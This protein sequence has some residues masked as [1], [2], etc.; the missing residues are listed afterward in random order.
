MC[1]R[2]ANISSDGIDHIFSKI[3]KDLFQLSLKQSKTPETPDQENGNVIYSHSSINGA[4]GD[5]SH[6]KWGHVIAFLV[7]AGIFSVRAVIC[8]SVE[9]VD[10]IIA[11]VTK[12]FETELS[13]WLSARGG[14]VS[15][16]NT[17]K[18]LQKLKKST[19]FIKCSIS[20]SSKGLVQYLL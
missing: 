19:C 15:L 18:H 14:W 6:I 7:L 5:D 12:F 8:N 13:Q 9:A 20:N 10:I 16:V 4:S 2:N 3:S 17:Y 11:W 1:F